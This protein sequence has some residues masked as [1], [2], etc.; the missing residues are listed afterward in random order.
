MFKCDKCGKDNA[1]PTIIGR[2]SFLC[3]ACW[4]ALI[5]E[6]DEETRDKYKC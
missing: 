5:N 3:S 6:L 1:M 2:H 4:N